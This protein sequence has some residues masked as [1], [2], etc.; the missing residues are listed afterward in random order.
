[1]KQNIYMF[2]TLYSRELV[3]ITASKHTHSDVL[4]DVREIERERQRQSVCILYVSERQGVASPSP[5]LSRLLWICED[6]G[7][8][9]SVSVW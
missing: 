3:Q 1:M 6:N 2:L 5:Y 7:V 4:P 8:C 9:L